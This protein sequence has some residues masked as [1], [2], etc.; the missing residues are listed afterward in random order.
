MTMRDNIGE[1]FARA[2]SLAIVA[3]PEQAVTIRHLLEYITQRARGKSV[4]ARFEIAERL[5]SAADT[6][7]MMD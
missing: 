4:R 1:K 6:I 2:I 3:G 5:R 7:E